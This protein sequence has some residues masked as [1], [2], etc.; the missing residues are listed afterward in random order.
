VSAAV[1]RRALIGAAGLAATVAAVPI[2]ASV[3]PA[4]GHDPC[5]AALVAD[6]RQ[7]QAAWEPTIGGEDAL[8]DVFREACTA[9][10]P[11]PQQPGTATSGD[12]LDKTLRELRD[13]CR[14]PEHEARWAAYER[15]HAAWKAK[16]AELRDRIMGPARTRYLETYQARAWAFN[17]LTAYPVR[18]LADLAEKIEIVAADFEGSEVPLEYLTDFAA[19]VRRLGG[20]ARA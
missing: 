15:D 13:A 18:S 6:F 5:W 11:E 10:G 16:E 1:S 7:K 8:M 12:M 20:E 2:A 9:I 14:T 19:D 17:A 4:T 3:T